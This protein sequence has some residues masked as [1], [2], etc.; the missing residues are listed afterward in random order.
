MTLV[1]PTALR[2]HWKPLAG[3]A[4]ALLVSALVW[5]G[6]AYQ[7]HRLATKQA[8][9]TAASAARQAA[10]AQAYHAYQLDSTARATE[11]RYLLENART[12]A[13]RNEVLVRFR[14]ALI[15]LPER[16]PVER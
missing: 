11:R 9:A 3:L 16:P 7:R 6:R 5:G 2:Q 13:Q 12:Q 10:A 14:P 4:L 8:R 15:D 1:L